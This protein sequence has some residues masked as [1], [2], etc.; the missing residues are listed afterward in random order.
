[1]AAGARELAD[2]A[3][4]TVGDLAIGGGELRAMGV[5][6]GPLYGRILRDLLERVTD[7]PSLNTPD[8]LEA[9]VR[10]RWADGGRLNGFA[11][12]GLG[13]RREHPARSGRAM[14]GGCVRE[15]SRKRS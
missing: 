6:P 13:A 8:A 5:A 1:V 2:A 4:L 3:P 12:A 11:H 15:S 10:E 9:L 14:E 7:D